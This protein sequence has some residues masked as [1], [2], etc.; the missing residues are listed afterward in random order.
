MT[1]SLT[2]FDKI[3]R[4]H[5][6]LD[7]HGR[8]LLYIDRVFTED[9]SGVLAYEAV[10]LAGESVRNPDQV[11]AVADHF[12]PTRAWS[13]VFADPVKARM[14]ASVSDF[15]E[16]HKISYFG[17]GHP[18]QGIGHV[19]GPELGLSLPGMTIVCGDSHTATHG[20]LGCLAFGI[21]STELAQVLTDQVNWQTKPKR[22][23]VEIDGVLGFGVAAKD[24]ILHVIMRLGSAAGVG[25]AVEYGG[26]AIRSLGV[27]GRMTISN[28]SIELGAKY[29]LVAP[30]DTTFEY[31]ATRPLV[32]KGELFE[33]GMSRWR[34][35]V[36]DEGASFDTV[37]RFD[38]AEIE[39][40]VTWGVTLDHVQP[41]G[42]RIPDPDRV[43]DLSLRASMRRALDYMDLKPDML[44]CDIPIDRIFIGTCTN[45]RLS[46]LRAAAAVL[47]GRKSKVPGIVVP[48]SRR[49]RRDAE[50]E[51]L[52][53]IFIEAGLEW[54]MPGCS[55][56]VAENGDFIP[57]GERCAST[58]NRNF[59]GRQGPGART[60]VMS[61]AMVAAAA[62]HGRIA[63][64]RREGGF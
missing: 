26:S 47:K 31:L 27:E 4:S 16:R 39:P 25:H 18:A 7:H 8:T 14:V 3:W 9:A 38:A 22:M 30:D 21:G 32:P 55:M 50:A 58:Q 24:V 62:L 20:G 23:L 1:T 52:D 10:D 19:V 28:M 37:A 63:D 53:R 17:L 35:L 56:C 15:A 42:G 13:D 61:P 40:T 44:V 45:G 57:P 54:R 60:H 46:D 34:N 6:V 43:A 36:S 49:V 41:V 48:G 11:I 5:T 64:V 29:G 33:R 12:V 2:L 51:G 59:V